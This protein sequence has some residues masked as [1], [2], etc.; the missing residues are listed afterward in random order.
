[1][2]GES[3]DVLPQLRLLVGLR[4]IKKVIGEVAFDILF[5]GRQYPNP[6]PPGSAQL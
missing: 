6:E 5:V 1:M 3:N 4:S 2:V